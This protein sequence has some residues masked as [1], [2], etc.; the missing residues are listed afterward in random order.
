MQ[1]KFLKTKEIYD[2][3]QLRSQFAYLEHRILGDSVVA[4]IGPCHVSLDN[5][6]D[7]ED[8]LDQS[9]IAGSEMVHF[10]IEYFNQSLFSGVLLQR[11]FANIIRDVIY[12]L[13]P[14]KNLKLLRQ[15][16]DIYLSD[17]KLSI[18]IATSSPISTLIHFAVNVRTEGVPVPAVGLKDLKVSETE[19][20]KK[21]LASLKNE[22]ESSLTAT[23]KVRPV[24]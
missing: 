2:G 20:I 7:G 14:V 10:I 24:E 11:L 22:F 13:S 1:T 23:M 15:G 12:E 16:D 6:V 18:S 3:T 9:S 8:F 19:F 4:W 17:K 5:M 21:C